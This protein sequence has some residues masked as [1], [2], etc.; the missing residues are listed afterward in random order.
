[1]QLLLHRIEDTFRNSKNWLAS[2]EGAWWHSALTLDF[3]EKIQSSHNKES[4]IYLTLQQQR[5]R[6]SSEL[7]YIKLLSTIEGTFEKQIAA[8]AL[9]L[10]PNQA[11][12]RGVA[13][14]SKSVVHDEFPGKFGKTQKRTDLDK[15]LFLLNYYKLER[16]NTLNFAKICSLA[17]YTFLLI[18]K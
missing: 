4:L 12:N 8:L 7:E 13:H 5:V 1:M 9:Q 3:D 6:I 17:S 18:E 2:L 11:D 15:A 14:I 10:L 16:E